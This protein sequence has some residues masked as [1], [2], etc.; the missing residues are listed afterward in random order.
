MMVAVGSTNASWSLMIVAM[1]YP[2]PPQKPTDLEETF[3]ELKRLRIKV[4]KAEAAARKR[5]RSNVHVKTIGDRDNGKA[6]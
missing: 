2:R 6:R 1:K 4:A 3:R 5:G